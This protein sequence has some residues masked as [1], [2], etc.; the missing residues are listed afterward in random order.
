MFELLLFCNCLRI[1]YRNLILCLL[2]AA[3]TKVWELGERKR[4]SR[5]QRKFDESTKSRL[6]VSKANVHISHKKKLKSSVVI[7]QIPNDRDQRHHKQKRRVVQ[8]MKKSSD[9]LSNPTRAAS[10]SEGRHGPTS[11]TPGISRLK[12]V[13]R[14]DESVRYL[15]KYLTR[16]SSNSL[17]F[18]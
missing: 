3:G 4:R 13:T 17:L 15:N 12:Q 8:A 11:S 7:Q 5:K 10:S 16:K 18:Y 14:G 2:C 1:W 6:F 9:T